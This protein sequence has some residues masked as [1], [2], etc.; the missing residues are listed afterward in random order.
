MVYRPSFQTF[1]RIAALAIGY[2]LVA[3]FSLLLA[4]DNTNASPVWPPSG[5][6]LAALM[7]FGIRL[8]PGILL[9]AFAANLASFGAAHGALGANTY[10][11][12]AFISLG[13]A[14]EAIAGAWLIHRF[15]TGN[16]FDSAAK[17]LKFVAIIPVVTLFSAGVGTANLAFSGIAPPE[18]VPDILRTWWIGDITGILILTP[19]LISLHFSPKRLPGARIILERQALI[20]TLM[21]VAY[22]VFSQGGEMGG[23]QPMAYAIT[24]ALILI[25][26]RCGPTT[27]FLGMFL[28]S[29]ISIIGTVK[30]MGPF[31]GGSENEKL[32]LLQSFAG[33]V[34]VTIIFLAAS[35]AERK[36][37]VLALVEANTG[38]ER[39]VEERTSE[40]VQSELR[41]RQ[42]S[43]AGFEG[44]VIHDMGTIQ[45]ANQAAAAMFGY[46][47]EEFVGRPVMENVAPE[48]VDAALANMRARS[49][50]P[51]VS[52]GL[53]KDGTRFHVEV[54][55]KP[56]DYLGKP[57]RVVAVRDITE[58]IKAEE[59]Q[60]RAMEALELANRAK[61]EFLATVSH[62]IRTPLNGIIGMTSALQDTRLD[63]EQRRLLE[64]LDTCGESLLTQVNG[65]LDIAKIEAGSMQL[66]ES[67]FDLGDLVDS[68]LMTYREI[69]AR[70]GLGFR[71]APLALTGLMVNGDAGRLRQVIQN[72]VGNAC[73]FTEKGMV[74]VEAVAGDAGSRFRFQL[75]VKD[76]GI[77]M[78]ESTL[79]RIF[80]PFVQAD[81]SMSRKFG[82]TGLGLAICSRFAE[83]M[84]GVLEVESDL[85]R[86]SE[87]RFTC[88][89]QPAENGDGR[90]VVPDGK[91]LVA[92]PSRN[93]A[94]KV[95]VVEDDPV[96]QEVA[97]LF[98]ARSGS[99]VTYVDS[100]KEAVRLAE[101][102]L[103]DLI[104]MD[105]Q[106]PGMDGF[107]AT[108]EI[109]RKE[110]SG[111]RVRIVAMTANAIRGD[112]ERCL[113]SGMDDYLSK[114]LDLKQLESAMSRV[115]P[116]DPPG[117]DSG[118]GYRPTF[119]L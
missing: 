52:V 59:L 89:L 27:A 95:L 67:R 78:S 22:G 62:E 119:E 20:L 99:Q 50:V 13:N 77:G 103:F 109:R 4:F 102:G 37:A 16:P 106:L 96:N 2:F 112:R 30:G 104:L 53:R 75:T 72:L 26:F 51:I 1:G 33:V 5:I 110:G 100:G 84:G 35:L 88:S 71:Y 94:M 70:K 115:R 101:G 98:L 76:T 118:M 47:V 107:D 90:V 7:A 18:M 87:F 38:L 58:R 73:K 21:L 40:I 69:A 92:N 111:R 45:L 116:A 113:D 36:A 74:S 54:R 86:G 61:S 56:I 66:E 60:V 64:I 93:R 80:K 32:L 29:C 43:N 15:I 28:V 57:M 114:P 108:R 82:G 14:C 79:G 49:E 10:A 24:P 48:S 117:E 9:G 68:C 63:H 81:A 85:G 65:I 23:A 11:V 12:S 41:L 25:A 44:L 3:R 34:S 42:L 19:L 91:P 97:R 8:W 39:R 17:G 105:C 83:L 31:S 6:A 55:G 46:S